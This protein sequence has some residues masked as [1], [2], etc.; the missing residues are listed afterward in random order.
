VGIGAFVDGSKLDVVPAD[1]LVL[2]DAA[3]DALARLLLS[4]P[5]DATDAPKQ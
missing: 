5:D 4:I 3:A 2:S 1:G